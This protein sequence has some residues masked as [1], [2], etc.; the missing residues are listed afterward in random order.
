MSKSHMP[1]IPPAEQNTKGSKT[2]P[3]RTANLN[4]APHSKKN[5][6]HNLKEQDHQGNSSRTQHPAAE[7]VTD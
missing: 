3:E 7:P 4:E 5:V 1:P 2:A 6:P